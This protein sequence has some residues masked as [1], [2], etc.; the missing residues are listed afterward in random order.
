MA[1]RLIGG[2]SVAGVVVLMAGFVSPPASGAAA[3]AT[4]VPVSWKTPAADVRGVVDTVDTSEG[5][6]TLG[7]LTF[8]GG[9]AYSVADSR[10]VRVDPAT[11]AV[12]TVAGVAGE[13]GCADGGT[14]AAARFG[15]ENHPKTAGA[16]FEPIMVGTD[17]RRLYVRD[18]GC[19]V[20]SVDPLTGATE[21]LSDVGGSDGYGVPW[22]VNVRGGTL[23]TGSWDHGS[24]PL[25]TSQEIFARD[26]ATGVTRQLATVPEAFD[27]VVADDDHVWAWGR[28]RMHRIDRVTGERTPMPYAFN[29]SA[30]GDITDR[31]NGP[32]WDGQVLS[33]GDY[34][35]FIA[36]G[37]YDWNEVG[38]LHKTTGERGSFASGYGTPE[39][40]SEGSW[41]PDARYFHYLSGLATDGTSLYIADYG[42]A[43]AGTPQPSALLAV[44]GAVRMPAPPTTPAD[45]DPDTSPTPEPTTPIEEPEQELDGYVALGD[46]FQSGEGAYDYQ[47]GTDLPGINLCHRSDNAYPRLLQRD[48]VAKD[49][50]LYFR[51]CSGAV[52]DDL[53]SRTVS[54]SR[55]PWS[56]PK[57]TGWSQLDW[58]A[59]HT[60]LVTI[61]IGGNDMRFSSILQSCILES[62]SDEMV[63]DWS[64]HSCEGEF[65]RQV[66]ADLTA[67]TT[68][69]A[70]GLTRLQE[71]YDKVRDRAPYARVVVVGYPR[72]YVEGGRS[73]SASDNF[74]AGI[75]MTDQRWINAQIRLLNDAISR[76]AVSMGSQFVDAY[77]L[78]NGAELC[79]GS[80]DPFLNGVVLTPDWPPKWETAQ[81][82]SYHP[83][84]SGHRKIADAI[85]GVVNQ[86]PLGTAYSVHP[87]QTI[88]HG[89]R[90]TN[91]TSA[92][93]STRWPG[94]DVVMSLRSPSGRVITRTTTASDVRHMVGPTY[95]TYLVDKPE[96]GTWTV[97]LYGADVDPQGE[98]T[99]LIIDEEKVANKL[100][101]PKLNARQSGR[102]VTVDAVGSRDT[103]GRIVE[104][105]WDFGD[106]STAVGT[107]A[108]HTYAEPGTYLVTLAVKDDAG[109]ESFESSTRTFTITRYAFGGFQAPVKP[110][111][112]TKLKPGGIVPM[113]F[114]LGGNQGLD[115]IKGAPSSVRV[116][117]KTGAT[118]GGSSPAN[119][120]LVVLLYEKVRD[121]YTYYW[122]TDPR[123]AGTCRTFSLP[124][125]DGST[126]VA[127]FDFR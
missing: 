108:S 113:R 106:G 120:G 105:L 93:F 44:H 43:W 99:R 74:C 66:E 96:K 117:C 31:G 20:R 114:S 39:G 18:Q 125:R 54:T 123:W 79:S 94:S 59:D 21:T 81:S 75:R 127:T 109:G 78:P 126:H 3:T 63:W 110:T 38:W 92:S 45:P 89:Y 95:E 85:N 42:A 13:R 53:E 103:D 98:E 86:V 122:V 116:D 67:L 118:I 69:Q 32:Y 51:A 4:P 111:G 22:S 7:G 107:T 23:Y 40:N 124:L 90:V 100:P 82:E 121:T 56:D 29:W 61:G 58:L 24:D 65:A 34:F 17:G 50:H 48:G 84:A 26:L 104:Y 115:I 73:N 36:P 15:G 112:A 12:T 72:F 80:S 8:V 2:V 33:V 102:T 9:S 14:G 35:F 19:G 76:A 88:T 97:S 46:S 91:G 49:M 119:A 10:I 27:V 47:V 101:A 62:I 11:G 64:D 5:L 68:R 52:I 87:G 28:T 30:D 16:I 60:D 70:N 25:T 37:F 71:V 83:T 41:Y 1:R 55:P 77:N 57:V 6:T